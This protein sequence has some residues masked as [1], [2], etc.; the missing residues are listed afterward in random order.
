MI[1]S[2][3]SGTIHVTQTTLI[4]NAVRWAS[5]FLTGTIMSQRKLSRRSDAVKKV[6]NATNLV[7]DLMGH[8]SPNQAR[9]IAKSRAF[10]DNGKRK[11]ILKKKSVSNA[12]KKLANVL[13]KARKVAKP[14]QVGTQSVRAAT[15]K[16]GRYGPPDLY[17]Y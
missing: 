15:T 14:G 16:S 7:S 1:R 2:K 13:R 10:I 5:F 17:R 6:R 8:L 12:R 9:N 11:E 4:S 3:L